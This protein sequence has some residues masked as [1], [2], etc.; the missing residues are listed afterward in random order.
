VNIS[1]GTGEE[2]LWQQ[3]RLLL[4]VYHSNKYVLTV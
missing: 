2:L 3:A 1:A 4:A